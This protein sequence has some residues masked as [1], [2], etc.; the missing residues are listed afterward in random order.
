MSREPDIIE[1]KEAARNAGLEPDVTDVGLDDILNDDDVVPDP[2]S[3]PSSG[4]K[5]DVPIDAMN[6]LEIFE[7]VMKRGSVLFGDGRMLTKCPAYS[8]PAICG[9]YPMPDINGN[10]TMVC[11]GPTVMKKKTLG[12]LSDGEYYTVKSCHRSC[13]YNPKKLDDPDR[14]RSGSKGGW[15]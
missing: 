12:I 5:P 13:P 3:S 4:G 14:G 15:L 2:P 8:S 7:A 11:T 10:P 6:E 1:R 9:M